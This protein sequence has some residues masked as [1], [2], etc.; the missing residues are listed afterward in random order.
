MC[1]FYSLDPPLNDGGLGIMEYDIQ[2]KQL[3]SKESL[4]VTRVVNPPIAGNNLCDIK[5]LSPQSWY[6]F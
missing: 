5:G 4:T 1:Q 2:M 3:M 6:C